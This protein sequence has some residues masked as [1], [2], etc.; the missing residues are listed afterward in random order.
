MTRGPGRGAAARHPAQRR[1][2]QVRRVRHRS[3]RD[4]AF[5]LRE[6]QR[7]PAVEPVTSIVRL[8]LRGPNDDHGSTLVAGRVRPREVAEELAADV[9]S[10]PDFVLDPV[11]LPDSRR[12]AWLSWNHPN[13]AWTGPGCAWAG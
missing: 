3:S 12:M 8:D 13:M 6:D 7:D 10:A 11:L 9:D 5:A 2:R 4:V 1:H